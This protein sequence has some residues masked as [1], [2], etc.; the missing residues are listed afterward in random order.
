MRQDVGRPV[1]RQERAILVS[2]S[3][4]DDR[5]AERMIMCGGHPFDLRA[6]ASHDISVGHPMLPPRL[7]FPR[8]PQG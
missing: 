3:G 4:I 7:V 8:F 2:Q 5:Q 6:P 1:Q